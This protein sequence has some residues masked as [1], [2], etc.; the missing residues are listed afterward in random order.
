MTRIGQ[1]LQTKIRKMLKALLNIRLGYSNQL[2]Q[3][4]EQ[5]TELFSQN[6]SILESYGTTK[7][8][9]VSLSAIGNE[10][11]DQIN[12]KNTE[13]NEIMISIPKTDS[14]PSRKSQIEQAR[15]WFEEN[16]N[17]CASLKR[18]ESEISDRLKQV[19]RDL[20]KAS[21]SKSD[22]NKY[23]K[24]EKKDK[25]KLA[26]L[27]RSVSQANDKCQQANEEYGENMMAIFEESQKDEIERLQSFEEPIK[28]V[29]QVLNIESPELDEAV[30]EYNPEDD[31]KKWKRKFRFQRFAA[32]FKKLQD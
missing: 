6:V 20:R 3:W 28:K 17:K 21:L 27:K 14:C 31:L 30:Q 23:Q 16:E 15:N 9:L 32:S 22:Q 19:T 7:N 12:E 8:L 29:I 24:R 26:E 2:V 4:S 18:Q 10:M 1:E 13:L 25:G 5:W 11:A